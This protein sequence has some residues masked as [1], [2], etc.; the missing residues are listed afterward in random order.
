M[1]IFILLA[2]NIFL[3]FLILDYIYD[4][5][6]EFSPVNI[7]VYCIK[8]EEEEKSL[9]GQCVSRSAELSPAKGFILDSSSEYVSLKFDQG[10]S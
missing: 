5:V 3:T 2:C 8:F 10:V 1:K 6:K 9:C 7:P 4:P